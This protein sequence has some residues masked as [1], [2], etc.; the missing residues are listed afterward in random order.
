MAEEN[1]PR[2][3]S[4]DCLVGTLNVSTIL[5]TK[6]WFSLDVSSE[7]DLFRFNFEFSSTDAAEVKGFGI[8]TCENLLISKPYGEEFVVC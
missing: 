2:T 7:S 1:S 3:F 8:S 6:E 4:I 5:P